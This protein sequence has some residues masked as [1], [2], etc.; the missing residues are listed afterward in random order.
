MFKKEQ[1]AQKAFPINVV[2]AI[3]CE[4][5]FYILRTTVPLY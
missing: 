4:V 3:V 5:E 1:K 2:I